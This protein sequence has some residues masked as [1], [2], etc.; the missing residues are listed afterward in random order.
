MKKKKPK[1]S[2]AVE[3]IIRCGRF[4]PCEKHQKFNLSPVNIFL[5]FYSFQGHWMAYWTSKTDLMYKMN[6]QMLVLWEELRQS[7]LKLDSPQ[8]KCESLYVFQQKFSFF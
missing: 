1:L 2:N 5:I 6:K 4:K 3:K 8:Y 7:E